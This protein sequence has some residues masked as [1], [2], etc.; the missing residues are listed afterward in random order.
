MKRALLLALV[1]GCAQ[2]QAVDDSL[3]LSPGERAFISQTLEH[4][5]AT[6]VQLRKQLERVYVAT[7][8]T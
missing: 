5:A 3:T 1:A 6:I 8:C 7:G 4:Q 2:A